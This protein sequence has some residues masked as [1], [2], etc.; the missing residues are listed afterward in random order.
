MLLS[1]AVLVLVVLA[2]E[3]GLR[4]ALRWPARDPRSDGLVAGVQGAILGL[5]SLVLAFSFSFAA[6]RYVLRR[7]LVVQEANTLSTA[8][9]RADLLE[10][11]DARVVRDDIRG[12]ATSRL[13]VYEDP[14]APGAARA[15]EESSRLARDLWSRVAASTIRDPRPQR[16]APEL[17]ALSSVFDADTAALDAEMDRLPL[18]IVLIVLVAAPLAGATVGAAFGRVGQRGRVVVAAFAVLVG[19]VVLSIVDL[20][21]ARLGNIRTDLSA[22]RS[23]VDT[24]APARAA[25]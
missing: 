11:I 15:R 20:D 25:P 23:T 21:D 2:A 1:L 4:V 5:V 17:T 10:P 13:L 19:L 3:V 18:A 8:Y 16:S 6:D 7:Q 14:D 22:L 9:L 12:Y 24:M